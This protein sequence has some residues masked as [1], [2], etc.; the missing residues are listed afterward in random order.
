MPSGLQRFQRSSNDG[1]VGQLAIVQ[2]DKPLPH[3]MLGRNTDVTHGRTGRNVLPF[4][5]EGKR[6]WSWPCE[7]ICSMIA[8]SRGP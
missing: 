8:G 5:R 1:G 6:P 7:W 2:Y 3:A 4:K